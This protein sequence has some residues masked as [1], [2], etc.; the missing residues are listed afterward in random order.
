MKTNQLPAP[1]EVFVFDCGLP[2]PEEPAR[3]APAV[4]SR[5]T[6]GGSF[7][8]PAGRYSGLSV[9][10]VVSMRTI[11]RVLASA[12]VHEPGSLVI[13]RHITSQGGEA[14]VRALRQLWILDLEALGPLVHLLGLQL[15]LT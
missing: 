5:V 9:K 13:V 10:V 1:P 11:L 15:E 6:A 12:V 3:P 2:L 7:L 8:A 4:G 14:N